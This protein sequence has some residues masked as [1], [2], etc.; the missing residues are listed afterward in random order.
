[1]PAQRLTGDELQALFTSPKQFFKNPENVA[2]VLG[3]S[4][5]ARRDLKDQ[6]AK[7]VDVS[8]AD[9]AIKYAGGPQ[10]YYAV[11]SVVKFRP[12]IEARYSQGAKAKRS[13]ARKVAPKSKRR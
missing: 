5:T 13:R 1:M 11:T 10:E 7:R 2:K 6:I 8:T 9:I 3:I 4:L 12:R